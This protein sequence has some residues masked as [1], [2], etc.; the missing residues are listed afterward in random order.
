MAQQDREQLARRI[1]A[2]VASG[3][4]AP[5]VLDVLRREGYDP[6]PAAR[7]IERRIAERRGDEP[8]GDAELDTAWY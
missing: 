6:L 3:L 8:E 5:G 4:D 1:D 2:L 7:E